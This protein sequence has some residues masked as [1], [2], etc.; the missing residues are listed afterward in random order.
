MAKLDR[1]RYLSKREQ[2]IMDLL[3]AHEALTAAQIE[4][5][6]PDAPSNSTVRS[7]LAIMAEKGLITFKK[8]GRQ[9]LY[10][11]AKP[12]GTAAKDALLGVVQRF[13]EGSMSSAVMTLV[14][15]GGKLT[16]EEIEAIQRLIDANKEQK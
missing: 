15:T 16:N 10:R 13:F 1:F 6:L 2:Q 5:L 4:S 8:D 3:S 11:V 9:F 14:E 12:K 7:L